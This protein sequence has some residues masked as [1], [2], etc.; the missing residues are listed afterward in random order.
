MPKI[1]PGRTF[2]ELKRSGLVTREGRGRPQ[3]PGVKADAAQ[4]RSEDAKVNEQLAKE[5]GETVLRL[6][7]NANGKPKFVIG[8]RLYPNLENKE[9]W[10]NRLLDH[11]CSCACGCACVL[12]PYPGNG[13]PPPGQA[14]QVSRRRRS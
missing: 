11:V 3:L 14:R 9:Y 5:I 12:G 4:N 7:G 10:D 8:W 1:G 6:K 2:D 13:P